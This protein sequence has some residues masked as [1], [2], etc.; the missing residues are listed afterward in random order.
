[1]RLV[2]LNASYIHIFRN[3]RDMLQFNILAQQILPHKSAWLK[4]A[5]AEITKKPFACLTI[6]LTPQTPEHLRF[7]TNILPHEH[8]IIVLIEKGSVKV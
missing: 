5:F 4:E 2:S 3:P 1:M 7:L 6:D 8:P